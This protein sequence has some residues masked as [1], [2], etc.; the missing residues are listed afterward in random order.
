MIAVPG[1]AGLALRL[2]LALAVA[3]TS[4]SRVANELPGA[5]GLS[6]WHTAS[7]DLADDCNVCQS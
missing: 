3:V 2:E 6:C 4:A 7:T 1:S 5:D